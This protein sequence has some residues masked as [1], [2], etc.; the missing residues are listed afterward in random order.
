[1]RIFNV[2][3]EAYIHTHTHTHY[4]FLCFNWRCSSNCVAVLN[5]FSHILHLNFFLANKSN[6]IKFYAH[7]TVYINY[8]GNPVL[9]LMFCRSF[10]TLLFI[11]I[12]WLIYSRSF[13]L[14]II[15]IVSFSDRLYCFC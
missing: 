7:S 10:H 8:Q 3:Q 15:S 4:V 12:I 9:H 5:F 6:F 2:M 14:M 11:A 13:I 1:M